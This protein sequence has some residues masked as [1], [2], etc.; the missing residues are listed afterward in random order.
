MTQMRWPLFVQAVSFA[1]HKH[2]DQRRKDVRKR[3]YINHPIE[4]ATLLME[5][6]GVQEPAILAAAILH[7]TIEDTQTHADELLDLFG[8]DV[9]RWVL[10]VTDDKSLSKSERKQRQIERAALKSREARL[11]SISDKTCNI[12]DLCLHPLPDWSF[13]RI[14]DYF[15]WARC[16]VAPMRGTNQALEDEFDLW[17]TRGLAQFESKIKGS[18]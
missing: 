14:Y 5:V 10:E 9:C 6:G 17:N 16:V 12:R 7:D 1:S 11:I 4:V 2:Q 3:P 18:L 8:E 15:V 13:Q